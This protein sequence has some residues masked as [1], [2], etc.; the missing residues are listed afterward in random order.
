MSDTKIIYSSIT[1]SGIISSETPRAAF[2]GDSDDHLRVPAS[3]TLQLRKRY[4]QLSSLGANCLDPN[5]S[6]YQRLD[7]LQEMLEDASRLQ[8]KVKNSPPLLLLENIEALE[9]D[10][11]LALKDD[12]D[13]TT[14]QL[15]PFAKARAEL[16]KM[17]LTAAR[18]RG[19]WVQTGATI[20][21]ELEDIETSR[22]DSHEPWLK[23]LLEGVPLEVCDLMQRLIVLGLE[24]RVGIELI[25][26]AGEGDLTE[27]LLWE[28]YTTLPARARDAARQIAALR[29]AQP[30]NGK[31]GDLAVEAKTI[32]TEAKVAGSAVA[33]LIE[34]G[35][36][37]S[38]AHQELVMPW[39]LRSYALKQADRW[40]PS[41]QQ[42][43][44]VA[45]VKAGEQL[46]L[47]ST[48]EM[49][50]HHRAVE[51]L[52]I[53]AATCY[54]KFYIDDL[55]VRGRKLSQNKD[56][57]HAAMLFDAITKHH[58]Q[59]AYAWEYM[60]FNLEHVA[61][62]TGDPAH[63]DKIAEGYQRAHDLTERS[64]PLFWAR[65]LSWRILHES[66]PE[67]DAFKE[68][69]DALNKYRSHSGLSRFVEL[70]KNAMHTK[71]ESHHE[72]SRH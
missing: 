49:E 44:W 23:Q 67:S 7:S 64:N 59:N 55:I 22:Y 69:N 30:Y 56:Y 53:E 20:P 47:T 52:D 8:S 3:L 38:T 11:T 68:F 12:G 61:R 18:R 58:N 46:E 39:R 2:Y 17:L 70:V 42:M 28:N 62:E 51:A 63:R 37:L 14:S 48:Q 19:I 6:W 36:L 32:Q 26:E 60:A 9:Q 16:R 43:T 50:L 1:P 24:D 27:H 10:I 31:L 57:K 66:L 5:A 21:D 71:Y 25:V 15:T 33:Q 45:L 35:W 72:P 41:E 54:S 13:G 65:W 29:G 40:T 4:P 34:R